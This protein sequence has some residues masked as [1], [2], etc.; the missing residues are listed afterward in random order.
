MSG[1]IDD[2]IFEEWAKGSPDR[3]IA[4]C[5]EACSC[6]LQL[7]F[8]GRD[9]FY[10]WNKEQY[11]WFEQL[12]LKVKTYVTQYLQDDLLQTCICFFDA[13][14]YKKTR[15]Y[16]SA[17][18]SFR[19]AIVHLQ[20]TDELGKRFQKKLVQ[21]LQQL[22][23][24]T[25]EMSDFPNLGKRPA[26]LCLIENVGESYLLPEEMKYYIAY[27]LES[28]ET[29]ITEEEEE[30]D[31]VVDE[32]EEDGED[33]N[34][35][36]DE[37]YLF[38]ENGIPEAQLCIGGSYLSGDEVTANL[39]VGMEW[40]KIAA[41]NGNMSAQYYL[42]DYYMKE[43]NL[44]MAF[45]WYLKAAEQG[46]AE[47]QFQLAIL[48]WGNEDVPAD[49]PKVIKWFEKAAE[50]KHTYAE[51]FLALLYLKGEGCKT[52]FTKADE[53]FRSV[54]TYV[55]EEDPLKRMLDILMKHEKEDKEED[56][57]LVPY[58][59]FYGKLYREQLENLKNR[60]E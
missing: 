1:I 34:Y 25:E 58:F 33:K 37:M 5:L 50:Q 20:Q 43:N 55:N 32:S 31:E 38:A 59:Q 30:D 18:I 57:E 22:K 45:D 39:H 10:P 8:Y 23:I 27:L 47:A 40:M 41:L 29:E 35:T 53:L 44:E 24:A 46:H 28:H 7:P 9:D 54:L 11:A 6:L 60:M 16:N 48:Y 51:F 19:Q 52:D 42:A 36:F 3:Y 12:L 49:Y 4:A 56:P 14:Y 17:A 2:S 13:V 21:E 15:R 26:I